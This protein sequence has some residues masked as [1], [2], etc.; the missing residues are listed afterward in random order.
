MAARLSFEHNKFKLKSYLRFGN[1]IEVQRQ[2]G[3]EFQTDP[4]TRLI[5]TRIIEKFE[6]DGT[7]QNDHKKRSGIQHGRQRAIQ[8]KNRY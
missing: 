2:P 1:A 3:R 4:P 8:S 6:A 7:I 5:I